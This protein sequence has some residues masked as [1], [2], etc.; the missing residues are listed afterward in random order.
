MDEMNITPFSSSRPQGLFEAVAWSESNNDTYNVTT[1]STKQ[2]P[3]GFHNSESNALHVTLLHPPTP[4]P[5]SLYHNDVCSIGSR[6]RVPGSSGEP[7]AL[8]L[9]IYSMI[10]GYTY[11]YDIYIYMYDIYIY[12]RMINMYMYDIYIYICMIYI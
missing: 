9:Y 4:H 5:P 11:M 12:T 1:S 10:Y 7:P 3:Q 8:S 2:H 6:L